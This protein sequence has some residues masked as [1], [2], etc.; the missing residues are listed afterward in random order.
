M[1]S[2]RFVNGGGTGSLITTRTEAAITEI[3]VGS[4]FYAPALFDTYRDFRYQPAAGFAI[5]IVGCPRSSLYTCLGGGYI[6]SGSAGP[7]AGARLL[8]REGAGEAQ[9][10]LKYDSGR[11]V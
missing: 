10:P 6:A 2:L 3:M 5:E 11:A 9:T 8:S 1:V 4:G 7:A